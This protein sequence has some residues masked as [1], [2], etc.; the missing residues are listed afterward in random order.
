MSLATEQQISWTSLDW[1]GGDDFLHFAFGNFNSKNFAGGGIIY[2][3]SDSDRYNINL[4]PPMRDITAEVPS[5]DGQ[6]YFGTFHQPKVFDINFAFDNLNDAQIGELKK[7]LSG[8]EL[9]ELV[10]SESCSYRTTGVINDARIYM[11]KVTGQPSIKVVAFDKTTVTANGETATET[12]SKI[13]KGEGTVQFTAYWPYARGKS[14][15]GSSGRVTGDIPSYFVWSADTGTSV[16]SITIADNT[17]TGTDITYWDSRTGIVKSGNA[18]ISYTGN[19][20]VTIPIGGKISADENAG[21]T[22]TCYNWYY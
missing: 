18:I 6:Y 13:Y 19:G 2:R 17:I 8:K 1:N 14:A 3:T 22:T 11:A 21:G 16:N 10:F 20:V 15:I 9:K 4:A 7:K 5:G 12:I